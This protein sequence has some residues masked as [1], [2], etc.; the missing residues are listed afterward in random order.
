MVFFAEKGYDATGLE[1]AKKA[2]ASAEEYAKDKK[3]QGS[4]SYVFGDFFEN[5][6]TA[7][8]GH[9]WDLIYDF[10]VRSLVI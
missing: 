1:V 2:I 8:V 6:W 4:T 9:Q 10:T 5:E 7:K 3:V